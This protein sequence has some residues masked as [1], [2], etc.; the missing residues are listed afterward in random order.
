MQLEIL[1]VPFSLEI[2]DSKKTLYVQDQVI[3]TWPALSSEPRAGNYQCYSPIFHTVYTKIAEIH[4]A[5]ELH[6]PSWTMKGVVTV[7][8]MWNGGCEIA[9]Q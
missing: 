6:L 9:K 1:K 4:Y 5:C 8:Y 7:A 3:A 2:F